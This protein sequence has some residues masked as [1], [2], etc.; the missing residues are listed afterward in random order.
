MSDIITATSHELSRQL[1]EALAA[2]LAADDTGAAPELDELSV[3]YP[4]LASELLA[5]RGLCNRIAS[6]AAKYQAGEKA[7]YSLTSAEPITEPLTGSPRRDPIA[8]EPTAGPDSTTR[9]AAA[10]PL[11]RI[12]PDA[13]SLVTIKFQEE[14]DLL[15]G[16][17]S[18]RYFGDYELIKV[19][20]RGGMGVVYKA[21]QLSL[22]RPVALKMLRA[23]M[24]ASDDDRQAV[25]E[26]GRGG[27][28]ARPPAHRAD[29]RGGAVRGTALLQHEADRRTEPG[30]EAG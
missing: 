7:A 29:L 20:G 23:G 9:E 16:G 4:E 17:T 11:V 14:P 25:P 30:Q 24:L 5:F 22:N 6:L 27:C 18:V 28:P 1:D 8:C 12:D 15:A 3:Q 2:R 10:T 13:T 26:R 19:L 21:R